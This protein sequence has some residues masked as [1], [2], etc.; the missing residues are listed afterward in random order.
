M[1]K[2]RWKEKQKKVKKGKDGI[3]KYVTKIV[4]FI[5]TIKL[6]WVKQKWETSEYLES[7]YGTIE[8][9]QSDWNS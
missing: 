4:L 7:L 2:K 1:P 3:I 6:F 9:Y 8:I 5:C